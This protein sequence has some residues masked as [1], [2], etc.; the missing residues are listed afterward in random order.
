MD[1]EDRDVKGC[2]AEAK[3]CQDEIRGKSSPP[4]LTPARQRQKIQR[5]QAS[6]AKWEEPQGNLPLV[7]ESVSAELTNWIKNNAKDLKNRQLGRRWAPEMVNDFR[8]NLLKF[9]KLNSEQPFQSA[10][11]LNSGSYFEKVKIKSADEFD[12]MLKLRVTQRPITTKLD[13][14]L[15]YQIHLAGPTQSPIRAFV[16]E[17]GRTISSSKILSEMYR[18]VR[19]FL[20]TYRVPESDFLWMVKGKLTYSPAVTLSL[21]K[22]KIC[23][24]ELISVDL[25]PALE[26]DIATTLLRNTKNGLSSFR[27]YKQKEHRNNNSK[28]KSWRISFSHIEKNLIRSHGNKKTCCE[29]NITKCCRKSCFMLLKSLIEGLKLRFPKE[30]DQLCSYHGKTVFLRTMSIRFDDAKWTPQQLP[31]CFLYLLSAMESHARTGLLPHFFVPNCNLFSPTVFPR[32]TLAFLVSALE[33]KRREGLPLLR[34][35]SPALPITPTSPSGDTSPEVSPD[36]LSTLTPF[37][38]WFAVALLCV[39]LCKSG[40]RL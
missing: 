32:K 2:L 18:L 34:H 16:L 33:E 40:L 15:F 30:L 23:S 22:N 28:K 3:Q 5:K 24:D 11:F 13:D 6:E 7:E 14:G 9:L 1:R 36:K 17:N 35:P 37:L 4:R 19:K 10:E 8:D 38:L 12:M 20:K 21:C 29:S 26:C 27:I 39:L 25:V 31:V